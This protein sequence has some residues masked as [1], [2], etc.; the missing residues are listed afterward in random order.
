MYQIE[1][2]AYADGAVGQVE[3]GVDVAAEMEVEEVDD[4]AVHEAI[5]EVAKNATAEQ[6]EADLHAGLAQAEVAAPNRDGSKRGRGEDRERGAFAGE[7][8]PRRA[9]VAHVHEI[10]KSAHDGNRAGLP[11]GAKGKA[12]VNPGLGRLVENDDERGLPDSR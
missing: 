3:G 4:V 7:E 6:A 12:G 2:N 10:E 1:S 11:V 8:A 5:D 9:G